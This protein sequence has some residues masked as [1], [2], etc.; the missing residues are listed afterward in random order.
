MDIASAFAAPRP[1][2][3]AGETRWVRPLSLDA[4]ATLHAWLDARAP[5]RE[6][7]ATP[8]CLSDHWDLLDSGEGLWV[9]VWLALRDAGFPWMAAGAV[10]G[11]MAREEVA[12]LI[13]ALFARRRTLKPA[14]DGEDLARLWWGPVARA[15]ADRIGLDAAGRL[16]LD[17]LDMMASKDGCEGENPFRRRLTAAEV[18]ELARA[19][20]AR[21]AAG[22]GA[23]GVAT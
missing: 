4:L 8:P 19:A 9:L 3:L 5:G 14:G 2:V 7:R 11:A 1:V 17:Q 15:L 22:A 6:G 21:K 20:R 16:T 18:E 23:A 13:E 10:A 12:P